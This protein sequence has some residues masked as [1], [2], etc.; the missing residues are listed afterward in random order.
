MLKQTLTL[1]V[2]MVVVVVHAAAIEV[3]LC[4]GPN[5]MGRCDTYQLPPSKCINFQGKL[6]FWNNNVTSF[7][8]GS[9]ITFYDDFKSSGE[10]KEFQTG[11]YQS[12]QG[13]G[14]MAGSTLLKV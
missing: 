9:S 4:T 3:L 2:L 7:R 10:N 6:S 1:L 13:F 5:F 11:S 8:A 14:K 12:M